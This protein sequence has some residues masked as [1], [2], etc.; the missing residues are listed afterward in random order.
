MLVGLQVAK[1]LSPQKILRHIKISNGEDL[2]P[3]DN[4]K[5]RMTNSKRLSKY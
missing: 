3:H 2:S 5:I 1:V 4:F